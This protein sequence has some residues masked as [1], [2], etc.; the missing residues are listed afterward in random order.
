M[1]PCFICGHNAESGWVKGFPPAPDSQK[2]GLCKAHDTE[3]NRDMVTDQWQKYL[4]RAISSLNSANAQK[5]RNATRLLSIF[6]VGGGSIAVPCLDFATPNQDILKVTTP[7]H[8]VV[9]FPL[10]QVRHYALTPLVADAEKQA[11]EKQA[12]EAKQPD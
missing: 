11:I 1:I 3:F 2:L 7:D 10:R 4:N 9:F 6:F 5:L 12:I 8:E